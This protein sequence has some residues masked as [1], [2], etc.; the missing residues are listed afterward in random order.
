ML[1][2]VTAIGVAAGPVLAE[3]VVQLPTVEVVGTTPLPGLGVPLADVPANVQMFGNR[4]LGTQRPPTLTQFLDQN[5]T[6]VER[7]VGARQR[8]PAGDHFPRLRR[9]AAARHAARHVGVP[10][11]RAR[12]RGVRRRRELGSAP[13]ARD[14]VDPAHPRIDA[15]V[16]P[17]YAGRRAGGVHEERRPI[18]GCERADRRRLVR[19]LRGAGR[20]RRR[21]GQARLVRHGP[22]SERPGLGRAQ[23]KPPQAVLRQGRLPGRHHR[24]RHQHDARRQH[25]R[26][27]ADAAAVDARQPE[28]GIYV[29]GQQPQ[30]ARVRRGE[31]Q[32]LPRRNAARS[33]ATSTIAGTRTRTSAATSTTT[34]ATPTTIRRRRTRRSTIARRSTSEAGAAGCSSRRTRRWARRRTSSPSASPATSAARASRR[35]RRPRT[36]RPIARRSRRDRS[37]AR[38]TRTFATTTTARTSATRSRSTR[39]GR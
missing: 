23:P 38:P 31:G 22:L 33:A 8:V 30:P 4:A 13:A 32:P 12:Q 6:S 10:G 35:I 1:G 24:S 28:A 19:R 25:A 16:R 9:F 36:S 27:L 3:E 17:Q 20:G 11:R 7:H 15:G 39:S 26:R 29:P 21:A 2:L 14:L 5:A 18:S 37:S 34:S